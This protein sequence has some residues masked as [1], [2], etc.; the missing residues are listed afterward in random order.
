MRAPA[1]AAGRAGEA[2]G[3]RAGTAGAALA[4][5]GGV[6]TETWSSAGGASEAAITSRRGSPGDTASSSASAARAASASPRP[7]AS[8]ASTTARSARRPRTRPSNVDHAAGDTRP[9]GDG[10]RA[11][12]PRRAHSANGR[13]C[14]GTVRRRG[15]PILPDA[16]SKIRRLNVMRIQRERIRDRTL[17]LVEAAGVERPL[18]ASEVRNQLPE[19]GVGRGHRVVAFR[20]GLADA[21]CVPLGSGAP[22]GL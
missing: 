1:D 5:G 8:C 10:P 2:A 15:P 9:A 4:A 19:G 14:T 18:R 21:R 20:P 7:R 11:T 12:D 3:R 16:L 17:R 6:G 22:P 13:D